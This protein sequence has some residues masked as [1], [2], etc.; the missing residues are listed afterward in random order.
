MEGGDLKTACFKPG[1]L[2]RR[3]VHMLGTIRTRIVV[4]TSLRLLARTA[5]QFC[6][7]LFWKSSYCASFLDPFVSTCFGPFEC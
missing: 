5:M 4:L 2:E 1:Q 3:A 7:F 6:F